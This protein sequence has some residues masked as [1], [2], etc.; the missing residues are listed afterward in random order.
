VSAEFEHPHPDHPHPV[1]IFVNRRKIELP[2]HHATG[3]EIKE[4]ADVPATF[5]LFDPRGDEVSNDEKIRLH[6]NEHFTAIS[7]QDVS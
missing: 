3:L 6:E 1:S 2:N 5:K 4:K 7:G